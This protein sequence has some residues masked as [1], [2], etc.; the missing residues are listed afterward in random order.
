ML[1]ASQRTMAVTANLKRPSVKIATGKVS[2]KSS[3]R[4]IIFKK[5]TTKLAIM[6]L[7]KLVTSKPFTMREVMKRPSAE[8]SQTSI[9]LI[10]KISFVISADIDLTME[11]AT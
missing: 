4:R 6:A 3:G 9:K 7:P 5:P 2:N 11:V 8:R 10:M 1:A